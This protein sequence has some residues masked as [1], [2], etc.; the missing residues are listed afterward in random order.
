MKR[1]LVV[2]FFMVLFILPVEASIPR[3]LLGSP[4][5]QKP[6]ILK[7]FLLSCDNVESDR[8]QLD[9][10][11]V[12]DNNIDQASEL[13]KSFQA[14]KEGRC[15]IREYQKAEGEQGYACNEIGHC[16]NEGL[17][18]KVAAFKDSII[19]YAQDQGYDYFRL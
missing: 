16:W 6:S 19:K 1:F 18:W 14:G 13:L 5:C 11:F 15:T 17:V 7:E 8:Y 9:F 4:V 2:L 3:V 12:D 10:Y